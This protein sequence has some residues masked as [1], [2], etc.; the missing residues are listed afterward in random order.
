[1]IYSTSPLRL[2]PS[3]R[4]RSAPVSAL[5]VKYVCFIKETFNSLSPSTS[6]SVEFIQSPSTLLRTSLAKCL[7]FA[8]FD[9]LR[10]GRTGGEKPARAEC[11]RNAD[12]QS[13]LS[14][15]ATAISEK[16]A[17]AEHPLLVIPNPSIS[18]RTSSVRNPSGAQ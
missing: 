8:P 2:P 9:E 4:L 5:R 7:G 17:Q 11:S 16:F 1:M 15:T 13:I 18:L 12:L 14:S 3:P 10:T 6:P